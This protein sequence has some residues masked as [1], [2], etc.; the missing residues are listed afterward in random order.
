MRLLELHL[1][2]PEACG[3]LTEVP[4]A[5]ARMQSTLDQLGVTLMAAI[6]EAVRALTARLD[7]A[8]TELAADFKELRDAATDRPLNAEELAAFDTRIATLE[9]MGKDPENPVPAAGA[10]RRRS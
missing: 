10:A 7:A 5:L 4:A 6:S 2:L 3:A 1:H 9:A 8:T